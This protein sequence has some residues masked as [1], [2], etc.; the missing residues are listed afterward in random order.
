MECQLQS[1]YH[2]GMTTDARPVKAKLTR[3]GEQTRQRIVAAAA[4]LMFERGVAGTTIEAVQAAATV[5][6]SQLYHYF[7]GKD[8]LVRAV[9]EHQA[10]IIVGNQQSAS[11]GTFE[12]LRAWRDM[13]VDLDRRRQ[14]R[15]GCPLGSLGS[16]LAETDPQARTDIAASFDRW[17][18]AIEDGLRTMRATG[19]LVP[20]AD[21]AALALAT[22]AALQGGLLLTQMRRDTRPL[23][24][25][26]DAMLTLIASFRPGHPGQPPQDMAR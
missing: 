11:L 10:D 12:G 19:Q 22:L 24:T 5:S 23:E 18:A 8:D 21:P 14:G 25:A 15:G 26:L 16:Q 2:R 13:V 4:D 20:E 17:Q 7:A 1:S 9:I 3:R 6:A